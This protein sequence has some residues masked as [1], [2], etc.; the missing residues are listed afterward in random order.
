MDRGA[1][2]KPPLDTSVREQHF[3]LLKLSVS[4]D[5]HVGN[6]GEGIDGLLPLGLPGKRKPL[7]YQLL[8]TRP[9]QFAVFSNRQVYLD[10]GTIRGYGQ[11]TF[12]YVL[13]TSV[14][15]DDKRLR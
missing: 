13:L 12:G 10:E 7:W 5:K 14:L 6:H 9:K 2:S 15:A 4:V 11:I 1:L 8:G 3:K